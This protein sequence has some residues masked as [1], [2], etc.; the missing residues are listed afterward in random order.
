VPAALS[1]LHGAGQEA[2]VIGEVRQGTRGV[3]I[4]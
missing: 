4:E 1:V 2:V 3:V